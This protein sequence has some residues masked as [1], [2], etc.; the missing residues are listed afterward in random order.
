MTEMQSLDGPSAGFEKVAGFSRSLTF[1]ALPAQ[2]QGYAALYLLDLIGVYT[3]AL[4]LDAG[5]IARNHAAR[6]W[7]AGQDAPRARLL[8]DGRETSLPGFAFATGT[9]IDNLDA[10]DG[11]QPSKGHAGAALFP[12]LAAFAQDKADLK[13][14][15]AL[16][17]LVLGYEVAYRASVALHATVPDYH[18]S[19]AWNA[20]GA[21]LIGARLRGSTDE[22]LRQALGIA[23]YHGPRSQMMREI[24]NPTMLH[25]GSGIGGAI[26]V[27]SL[28]LAEEGFTGA[29]AATVEFADAAFAWADLGARWLT[30][31]QYIKPYPVCRWAH[32]PIDAVLGL[33]ARHAIDWRAIERVEIASFAYAA[34]LYQ[35]VPKSS[36]MAQ[37]S[38][39]WPVA[40]ALVRGR[41]DV[42]AVLEESFAD[43]GLIAMTARVS[44]SVDDALEADYPAQRQA[45]ATI[46]LRDGRRYESPVTKAS[47]GPEPAPRE[48]EIREKFSL[49]ATPVLGAER[50]KA[51]ETAVLRLTEAESRFG[52]VLELLIGTS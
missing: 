22:T 37:Y 31:E 5:R 25:D 35:Q 15:E 38:L 27:Q 10:H 20:L 16:T 13:G 19:G 36:P 18:T 44:A 46:F 3:A 21:A 2:V 12:A 41:V 45:R 1:D 24:A 14:Q 34:N 47:G 39:A 6:H 8:L 52:E 32:A 40:F 28:L 26:G 11:W 9:Q 43:P 30:T 48:E 23:E 49:Y 33:R 4:P 17:A 29:P 7:A 51:I 50:A 42:E